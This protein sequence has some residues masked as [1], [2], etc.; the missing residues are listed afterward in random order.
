MTNPKHL[1]PIGAVGELLVEGP[2]LADGYWQDPDKTEATFLEVSRSWPL[3]LASDET[4]GTKHIYRTGDLARYLP[5]G[6]IR[7]C[8]RMDNQVKVSGQRVEIGEIQS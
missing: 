2:M 7:L 6:S 4:T 5:G 3:D 1:A 8:G